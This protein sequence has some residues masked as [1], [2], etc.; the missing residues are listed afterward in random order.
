METFRPHT[1]QT[2]LTD[3]NS[4]FINALSQSVSHVAPFPNPSE[5]DCCKSR[6]ARSMFRWQA[7]VQQVQ[8]QRSHHAMHSSPTNPHKVEVSCSCRSPLC[9]SVCPSASRM[10][11]QTD[12]W[13]SDSTSDASWNKAGKTTF[14][15][16]DAAECIQISLRFSQEFGFLISSFFILVPLPPTWHLSGCSVAQK[17]TGSAL[18]V[19]T[20]LH[21]CL[22]PLFLFPSHSQ[23]SHAD[24][25]RLERGGAEAEA[26]LMKMTMLLYPD[27]QTS[28]REW[29]LI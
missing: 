9:V 1:L 25:I 15:T 8:A 18:C 28:Q 26:L 7:A 12:T 17:D 13:S 2:V 14:R 29:Q 27:A 20:S 11:M 23:L 21:L 22:L 3:L 10:L 5:L 24:W 4:K 19:D 16:E 6:K